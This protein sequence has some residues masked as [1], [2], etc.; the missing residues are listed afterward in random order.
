MHNCMKVSLRKMT[1]GLLLFI[2]AVGLQMTA[3][4]SRGFADWYTE[5]VYP[6]GVN[7]IGRAWSLLPC[8]GVEILLYGLILW[9]LLAAVIG[10][11]HMY[12]KSGHVPRCCYP[13][14]ER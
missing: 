13:E 2:A 7:T 3:R 11:R 8:S 5:Y 4:S 12:Q 6:V 14:W 1:I 9:L 10:L